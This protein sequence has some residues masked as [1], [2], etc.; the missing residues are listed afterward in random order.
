MAQKCQFCPQYVTSLLIQP[1]I[2]VIC[3]PNTC[4]MYF[5]NISSEVE[6]NSYDAFFNVDWGY[7][8][9]LFHEINILVK[10]IKSKFCICWFNT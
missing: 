6:R 8:L 2:H 9:I 10:L 4:Y 1:N 3:L 7:H 5:V